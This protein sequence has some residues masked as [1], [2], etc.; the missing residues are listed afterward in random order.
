MT[1]ELKI[2]PQ[3]YV[4]VLERR[5]TFEVRINDRNYMVG[6]LVELMEYDENACYTGRVWRGRITYILNDV[7]YVLPGYVIFSIEEI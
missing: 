6:D 4:A 2:A 5:K 3:Y 7:R 1:H